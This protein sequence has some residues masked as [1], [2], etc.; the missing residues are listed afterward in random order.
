MGLCQFL[1]LP[2]GER[3]GEEG[4]LQRLGSFATT[5]HCGCTSA[6]RRSGFG[7]VVG[8]NLPSWELWSFGVCGSHFMPLDTCL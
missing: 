3:L 2:P 1:A 5:G 4:H 8:V 7:C 6:D